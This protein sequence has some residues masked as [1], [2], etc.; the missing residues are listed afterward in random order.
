MNDELKQEL[1]RGFIDLIKTYYKTNTA[2]EGAIANGILLSLKHLQFTT[3]G[4][5]TNNVLKAKREREDNRTQKD[6]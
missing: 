6:K 5:F 1:A 4:E 3:A 2:Q